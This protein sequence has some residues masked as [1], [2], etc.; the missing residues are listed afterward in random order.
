MWNEAEFTA[1]FL[2]AM[3]QMLL[4]FIR[5]HPPILDAHGEVRWRATKRRT[6]KRKGK[7]KR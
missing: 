4:D 7:R 2:R 3:E 5:A 1:E 6:A